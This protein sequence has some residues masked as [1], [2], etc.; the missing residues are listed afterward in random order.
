[1][2]EHHMF[3]VYLIFAVILRYS[4]CYSIEKYSLLMPNVRPNTPEI[5]LCTPIKV[6]SSKNYYIVAFEPNATMATAHHMLLYGCSKPGSSKPV[7]NCGEMANDMT[8]DTEDTASPCSEGSEIIYA[9]ARDAPKL[10][11]PDGVGF[12]VGGDSSIQYLVL[13]VHYAHIDHFKDGS[14][15]D[16]GVFLH[17]TLRPLNK[18]AGV[19]LLG[20]GGNIPPK[21]TEYMETS[22]AIEEKKTIY[23]FAYR[24]HTHTL[25]RVVSGY[26]VK[27]NSEWIELGKRDPMKPQMFYPIHINVTA[28]LGDVV[29][30]RC[31]M[32]ND[33]ETWTYVGSTNN[34]EMCNFYLMYYVES[35]EP[36][37]KKYCFTSGP[38]KYYWHK[39]DLLNIPDREASTL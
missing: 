33:R 32:H 11:L 39:T 30:A 35:K 2:T 13:Q 25:G 23:P 8:T 6:D 34:D 18:L 1:M 19:L 15:D 27:Q 21:S 20:T 24:V 31:T 37:H 14:T 36:L 5:Y 17:Y 9:W 29:A 26:L 28:T 16:S 12:K 7:W 38:P 4:E 3:I 22:C 10:V